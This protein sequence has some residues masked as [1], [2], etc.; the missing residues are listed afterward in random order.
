MVEIIQKPDYLGLWISQKYF[1]LFSMWKKEKGLWKILEEYGGGL[2]K[3][4]ARI[5][6]DNQAQIKFVKRYQEPAGDLLRGEI[7]YS[8]IRHGIGFYHGYWKGENSK[9]EKTKGEF[10]L[11]SIEKYLAVEDLTRILGE[12]HL[13]DFYLRVKDLQEQFPYTPVI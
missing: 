11:V 2:I 8:G 6:L 3:A 10:H 9:G 12:L 4:D 7:N 13:R 5:L 1:A